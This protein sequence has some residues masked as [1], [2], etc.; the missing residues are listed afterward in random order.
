[1]QRKNPKNKLIFSVFF[2]SLPSS[3]STSSKA[4]TEANKLKSTGLGNGLTGFWSQ[5]CRQLPGAFCS[6]LEEPPSDLNTESNLGSSDIVGSRAIW[7]H[8]KRQHDLN[9]RYSVLVNYDFV[10]QRK[11]NPGLVK[12]HRIHWKKRLVHCYPL[13]S[14]FKPIQVYQPIL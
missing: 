6:D 7:F 13:N 11:I 9:M 8:S 1:M 10:R 12:P 2:S 4:K 14:I 5:L 3:L